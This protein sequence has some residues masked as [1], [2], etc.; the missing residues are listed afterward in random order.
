[1]R[2]T[3]PHLGTRPRSHTLAK[4]HCLFCKHRLSSRRLSPSCNR[5]GIFERMRFWFRWRRF[6]AYLR[7][8]HLRLR[9][10]WLLFLSVGCQERMQ[11]LWSRNAT[12]HN[13]N[14]DYV[15][16]VDD[17]KKTKDAIWP[18]CGAKVWCCRRI[19]VWMTAADG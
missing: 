9:S 8:V 12:L 18:L 4:S 10:P 14:D 2:S 6:L 1:M 5:T 16:D 13:I 19:S 11:A 7:I 17:N 15:E 3:P